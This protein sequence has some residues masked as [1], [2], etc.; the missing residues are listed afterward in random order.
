MEEKK[1]KIN[2]RPA[3]GYYRKEFWLS[4]E[5]KEKLKRLKKEF[6]VTSEVDVIRLLLMSGTMVPVI[7]AEDMA[8]I[9]KL[10]SLANGLWLVLQ[11]SRKTGFIEIE[12]K[13]SGLY[14]SL[15][16]SIVKLRKIV[17]RF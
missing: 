3:E 15:A 11:N 2:H 5:E 14:D 4:A 17:N 6:G 1:E 8:E 7:P 13:Y 12:K 16:E 9:R 10:N